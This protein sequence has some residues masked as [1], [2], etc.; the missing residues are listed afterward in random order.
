M[1]MELPASVR[2]AYGCGDERVRPFDGGLV[3]YS[4]AVGEPTRLVL[5]GINDRYLS[6]PDL[7]MENLVRIVGHLEWNR[8]LGAYGRARWYPVVEPTETGRPYTI[9]EFGRVWRALGYINAAPVPR[10]ADWVTLEGAAGLFGRFIAALDDFADPPLCTV[11]PEFRDT[12]RIVDEFT[13]AA[14]LAPSTP[15]GLAPLQQR[16]LSLTDIVVELDEQ[17]RRD[18][19]R[20]RVVHNDTKLANCLIDEN[21]TAVAVIDLDL[22]MPG[23]AMDD[24]GDL[25]RSACQYRHADDPL[26][27]A[28]RMASAFVGGT[29]GVL[30][31][32]EVVSLASG[33]LRICVQLAWRYLADAMRPD[34]LLRVGGPAAA[35]DKARANLEV[36]ERLAGNQ[37]HLGAV[38]DHA[39]NSA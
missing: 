28:K 34:P 5:Q 33:P 15:S 17:I 7:V 4:F 23:Y 29:G 20:T 18:A 1:E 27:V 22:A 21:A 30:D 9:D 11:V 14:Q 19:L 12:E 25:V 2:D 16:A 32:G 3:N 31:D 38:I 13:H 8:A 37:A 10:D 36:A 24:Y 39:V 26:E 6:Q 35:L